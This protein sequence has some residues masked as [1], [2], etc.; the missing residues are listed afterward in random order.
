[1]NIVIFTSRNRSGKVVFNELIK[2]FP[3]ASINVI[4]EQ[5]GN[6]KQ[7]IKRRIKKH[8]YIKVVNQLIFQTLIVKTLNFFSK[9]RIQELSSQLD[10]TDIPSNVINSVA[11]I[12][13]QE[14]LQILDNLKP[15]LIVVS[16]TRIIKQNIL[17]H[18]SCP[19][20]NLHAGVTPEYRG[21]HGMYWALRNNM[22]DMAGVTLHRVDKGIDTGAII[23]QKRSQKQKVDNFVTYPLIQL[24]D[25]TEILVD[26]IQNGFKK[27]IVLSN[28]DKGPLYYHPTATG[29]LYHYFFKGVK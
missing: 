4:R 27:G 2:V 19:I 24:L 5:G 22:P 15:D 28:G 16:G 8:G 14:V 12:N 9:D 26:Y 11:T 17:D 20:V 23:S 6:K 18:L 7:L 25:S 13:C 21:V 1:M 29:Y 3:S 10:F